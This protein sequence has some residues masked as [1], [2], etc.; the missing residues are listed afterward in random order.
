MSSLAA[1][2]RP[3]RR[4]V[5]QHPWRSLAA[6]I[7]IAIPVAL[8][9]VGII[10]SDSRSSAQFLSGART[11]ASYQGGVC[12]QNV[13]G[14][15][16]NCQGE[17]AGEISEYT[18]LQ[19][20]LPEDF[21][22]DLMFNGSITATRGDKS[23]SLYFTQ[24]A[25]ESAPEA[26]EVFLPRRHME[27]LDAAVGDTITLANGAEVTISQVTPAGTAVFP[28][29][30]IMAVEEFTSLTDDGAVPYWGTWSITGPQAFTWD[31]VLALNA[32]GFTVTSQDVIDNPPPADQIPL[33]DNY[34]ASE[35]SIWRVVEATLWA[36]PTAIIAFLLLMLISPVFTISVS[37]Q[38]RNFA[39]LASQGA[40]PRHIHWAV[41]IYGLFA[42][43]VGATLGLFLGAIG[44]AIWWSF[45]YPTF[46]LVISWGW[47][48]LSWGLA[49]CGSTVAAFLP[50][51]IAGR[52]D[53]IRGVHGGEADRIMRWRKWMAIGPVLLLVLGAM[54]LYLQLSQNSGTYQIY[55][56]NIYVPWRE[57]L[58]GFGVFFAVVGVAASAPAM[59]WFLGHIRGRLAL[60][61]AARDLLRQS[62]R[63]I[64]A[65]AAL[66]GVIFLGTAAMVTFA[67]DTEKN[68]ATSEMVYPEGTMFLLSSHGTAT[69]LD[70][71]VEQVDAQ[72][73]GVERVDVYGYQDLDVWRNLEISGPGY[74]QNTEW[75]R[76]I[77][78][79]FNS[80]VVIASPE[81]MDFFGIPDTNLS[82]S[83]VL[84]SS[85]VGVETSTLRVLK[86]QDEVNEHEV[87][88]SAEVDY[89]PALPPLSPD[90]LVTEDTFT[91]LGVEKSY[92]GAVLVAGERISYGDY[93]ELSDFFQATEG[94]NI[95]FPTWS[96]DPGIQNLAV[97]AG[98]T[99]LVIAVMALVL[100][101]SSQQI[102]RQKI[103]LDAVGAP[104]NL[105]RESNA[106]FGALCALGA[107][108]LGLITGHLGAVLWA[109]TSLTNDAGI[110]TFYGTLGFMEPAWMMI[111]G[112]LIIAPL[113]TALIG[114]AFTPKVEMSNYRD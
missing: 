19:E 54:Y 46:P 20:N 80:A 16:S 41:L 10:S 89:R 8:V 26:G 58:R 29:P 1:A 36:V 66:A 73:G 2:T 61:L 62:M 112:T 114:G 110:T 106:L 91:A 51:W 24:T 31:D 28:E 5:M 67:A 27:A 95:T 42:G 90:Y 35:F 50:A 79:S 6:I 14:Y 34:V 30:T 104:P 39:L 11:T 60:R 105:T 33:T 75:V 52:S 57:S 101:L 15:A 88:A 32:V 13:T 69:D 48:A 109:S 98:I 17:A 76:G 81:L 86:H 72:V 94:A 84:T 37:R 96:V 70:P 53:I 18:L 113:V 87:I 63:S 55:S 9:V 77:G 38:T 93:T 78:D 21:T 12:E 103:I 43:I 23:A 40:T 108:L 59:V 82:G 3:T 100:A 22:L 85:L 107:A 45:T 99:V 102:R 7:L 65:M 71:S 68:L 83:G 56:D 47:L 111:L 25:A 97:P 4:D 49:V 92:L 44:T 64:P 74:S